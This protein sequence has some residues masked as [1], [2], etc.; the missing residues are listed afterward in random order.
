M[1]SDDLL[2]VYVT[3]EYPARSQTFVVSEVTALREAG[4]D[5]LLYPM[6]RGETGPADDWVVSWTEAITPSALPFLGVSGARALTR[7]GAVLSQLRLPPRTVRQRLKFVK[8]FL[9]AC[10]LAG[11]VR[12][13]ARHR[14]VHLH[15]HFFGLMS[16][17][18]LL[19]RL[20]LPT[21]TTVSITGH[22]ADVARPLSRDRLVHESESAELVACASQFV[23]NALRRSGS[24]A[25]SRIVH[26]GVP[27][28]DVTAAPR[29]ADMP[30]RA[31]SVARL[32][33]KKGLDDCLRACGVLA[34][35]GD[36]DLVLRVVG[37]G[38]GRASLLD[39]RRSLQL[40]RHVHMYGAQPSKMVFDLLAKH[41]DIFVLPCKVA[42]DGDADGIPVVLMEAMSFGIPVVTTPV[43]GIPELVIDGETGIL[44]PPGNFRALADCLRH[45]AKDPDRARSVGLCGQEFVR[46][47]FSREAEALALWD[48]IRSARQDLQLKRRPGCR[49]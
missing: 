43:S 13:R 48:G 31:V 28:H 22:A 36:V 20:M 7:A 49:Q 33:E 2:V 47:H 21:G 23:E 45:L 18:A 25:H 26:C 38:P 15:A 37:D 35:S 41:C 19:T 46:Q 34:G 12:S 6:Q 29:T 39:L 27:R 44:V 17:V 3:H 16:E 32:V 1:T 10:A 42:R 5:V 11:I 24:V 40:E 8:A 14:P 30:L 9:L 4:Q